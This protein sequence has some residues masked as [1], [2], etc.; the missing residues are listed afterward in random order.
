MSLEIAAI[1]LAFLAGILGVLSPCVWPLIPIVMGS[2]A[3]KSRFGPYALALGLSVS[4]AVAGTL[5]SFLLV[6]AH[7][8]PELFR[9]FAALLLVL[10]ALT[11]ISSRLGEWISIKLSSL[12]A[13]F[14]PA[15]DDRAGWVGQFSLGL[16]LGLVWL[17]CVGPTLGA[18]IALASMGQQMGTAFIVMLSFGLG[19]A[20][21]LLIAG[22]ASAQAL[23]KLKPEM[24]QNSVKVK[25]MLG[26]LLMM[27]GLLVLTGL[28]KQLE[29]FALAVIPDW[30]STL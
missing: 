20:L 23:K 16:L 17:P 1:P 5:L 3:G 14:S 19:T 26:W 6:N 29:V 8:D 2:A 27:L 24:L 28:D 4:F 11:L 10:A 18:A 22:L 9:Y 7:L 12:T 13:R 15:D 21:V 25:K 30:A